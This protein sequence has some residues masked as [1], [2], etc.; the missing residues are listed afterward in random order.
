MGER[1]GV[2]GLSEPFREDRNSASQRVPPHPSPL[3]RPLAGERG[4][5]PLGAAETQG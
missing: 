2:R 5:A 3:P 4:L 1:V